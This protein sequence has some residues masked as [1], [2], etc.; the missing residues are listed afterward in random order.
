[1]SRLSSEMFKKKPSARDW[2]KGRASLALSSFLQLPA[3][4]FL[5]TSLAQPAPSR[6]PC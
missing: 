1:M 4:A 6:A 5:L 2:A 3:A